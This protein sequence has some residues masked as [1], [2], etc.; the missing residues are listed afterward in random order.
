MLA[1]RALLVTRKMCLSE[2]EQRRRSQRRKELFPG[3]DIHTTERRGASRRGGDAGSASSCLRDG[4][5]KKMRRLASCSD[6]LAL[7]WLVVGGFRFLHRHPELLPAFSLR[8]PHLAFAEESSITGTAECIP[9]ASRLR[10]AL[11]IDSCI[12]RLV[13]SLHR[14]G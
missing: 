9:W 13:F 14:H 11:L 5:G 10:S 1:R 12:Y 8:P 7:A 2:K 4:A 6:A 3:P